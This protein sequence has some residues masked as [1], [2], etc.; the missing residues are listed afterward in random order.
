MVRGGP[1]EGRRRGREETCPGG[2]RWE[3]RVGKEE[4]RRWERD[5]SSPP[6]VV[7]VMTLRV[8]TLSLLQFHLEDTNNNQ[9]CRVVCVDV[10]VLILYSEYS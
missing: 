5:I 10:Q 9:K 3:G 2:E 1:E 6:L 7:V 8:V 4:R